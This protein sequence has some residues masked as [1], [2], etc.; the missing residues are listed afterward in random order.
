MSALDRSAPPAPAPIRSFDFPEV[1]A[2]ELASG[3]SVRTARLPRLPL[4][5]AVLVIAA[6]ESAVDE[7][8]AG[9]AVLAADA[10]EGGTALRT[11][12]ELAEAFESI[13]AELHV[14]SGWDATTVAVTCVA[15]RLPQAL[16]LIA[17]VVRESVF[18]DAEVARMR[19]QQLARLRQRAMDPGSLAN[20][21]AARLFYADGIPYGRVLGG[22]HASVA[23]F[24][25][26]AV[27]RFAEASY[28]PAYG[29]IVLSGDVDLRAAAA[30]AE[31]RFAGWA[32]TPP[33]RN[34]P[35]AVPRSTKRTV[36]VVHRPGSV[37]SEL[38]I[39]YPAVPR[40]HADYFPLI[41]S[42]TVLGGAFTSRLNLSL[43]ERHGFT[44]GVRSRFH[45]RRGAGP[46]VVSTS[47]AS[48]VTAPAVREALI[49]LEKFQ[50]EGPSESEVE[51]ARD[52]IAGVFPLRLETTAQLAARVAE[53]LIFDLPP[54]HHT[55]YRDH[56]RAVTT[57]AARE[58]SARHVRPG[59]ATI[60]IVGDADVVQAPL[61]A[62][63]IGPVEVHLPSEAPPSALP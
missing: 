48:E 50:G 40:K 9:L 56:V 53:L 36:H 27:T 26:E 8:H 61:A 60:V 38:R 42:Y 63:E 44:Y 52:F 30:L 49:E 41:V 13:G 1:E 6:S 15:E 18:P 33:P 39:G 54:D 22:T 28:R 21:W 17:E 46:F 2:R 32:G 37:Q 35:A 19:D 62:L 59:E 11:A 29:G 4:V 34:D 51:A 31:E 5:S 16:E 45:F 25:R 55:R 43:R 24:S 23:S 12:G 20:D 3:L 58:A 14:A 10:L 7:E 47:V 57:E